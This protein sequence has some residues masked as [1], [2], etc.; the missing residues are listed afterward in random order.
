MKKFF[1]FLIIP[2]ILFLILIGFFGLYTYKFFNSPT[3]ANDTFF[4][5]EK[6]NNFFEIVENLSH[7]KIINPLNKNLFLYVSRILYKNKVNI[8]A[9]EYLFTKNNT[10]LEILKKLE[11][12]QIYYRKITFAEGLSNDTILKMIDSAEG[13]IGDLPNYEIP[14]GTLLPETYLYTTGETKKSIILR[15]QKAM[16][17]YFN[18]EWDNRASDLPFKTKQEALSLASIVEKETGINSERGKVASVFI[19]RLKR[20]M[21]LQ[22][23]P[24]VVYAFTKGNVDLER[25]IRKSD[26]IRV[27][28]YNTYIIKGI[29][30]KPIANPGKEAIHATLHPEKTN[31][32]YFVATGTGGHNFSKTL[33]EHN[34]FVKKYRN[35]VK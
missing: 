2:S 15:M 25:P 16:V 7:K 19:N 28:E 11:K 10:P 18:K 29:P 13:L 14:E 31:Y 30:E 33:K 3:I 35:I 34:E 26:L 32:L 21:R 8:K 23:D 22:S 20:K 6:G 24:T 27:S 4:V 9:G 5:V 1:K 17:E 12:G